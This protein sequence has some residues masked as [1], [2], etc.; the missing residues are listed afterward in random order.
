MAKKA[1]HAVESWWYVLEDD[2][3]L[4]SS[5]QSRFL[6][7][8]LTVAER[9][10]L[11]DSFV[12]EKD[13]TFVRALE[14]LV[15]HVERVENFPAGAPEPWPQKRAEREAYIGMLPGLYMSEL[16]NEI[17]RHAKL[18]PERPADPDVPRPTAEEEARDAK[19]S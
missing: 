9:A 14:L 16:A 13:R 17:M 18:S 19:N 7:R 3:A 12:V 5:E 1:G 10:A 15:D 8:P 2:R 11:W 4:P 6:L